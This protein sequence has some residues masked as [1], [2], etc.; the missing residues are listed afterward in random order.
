MSPVTAREL[1][2]A[3]TPA[4]PGEVP[5]IA[6]LLQA[7]QLPHEDFAPHLAHFLVARDAGGAVVGA[8]GA[9]VHGRDALLRS[10]VVAPPF[11]K[12]GLGAGLV[13]SLEAAAADWGVQH[14]WLLTTTA[15]TFFKK[16]GFVVT[17]RQAAPAVIAATAEFRGLCPSVAVCLSRERR[18]R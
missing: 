3:I 14:W 15:E 8:I 18:S 17:P 9:E 11:R 1:D 12:H 6:A 4:Q 2:L 13:R 16:R 7:A 10:L 5:S